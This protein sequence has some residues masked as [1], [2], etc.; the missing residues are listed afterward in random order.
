MAKG[1][2]KN[3]FFHTDFKNVNFVLTK[4]RTLKKF[5]GQKTVLPIEK[6]AKSVF[7]QNFFWVHF[8]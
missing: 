6:L 2:S 3:P 1:V 5:L 4:K 7:G 8:Y